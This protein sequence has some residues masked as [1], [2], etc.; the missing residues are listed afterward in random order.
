MPTENV[1]RAGFA[2][3]KAIL[4]SS[5]CAELGE[6]LAGAIRGPGMRELITQRWC[7]ALADQL[8]HHPAL[9]PTIGSDAVAMQCLFFEKSADHNWLVAVHQDLVFPVQERVA[10]LDWRAWSVKDGT[11][12][13]QPP[14]DVLTQLVAVRLHLD[15]CGLEDGPLWVVPGTHCEGIIAPALAVELRHHERPCPMQ[16]GDALLMRPL[17]LHRSSKATGQSRRR[18]LH[19]VFGPRHLPHGLRWRHSA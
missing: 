13:V 3:V 14:V 15:P 9:A 1:E 12:Y 17:L 16:Q 6:R 18:V 2:C 10:H 11:T 7:S 8:R 19:V 5:E 4:S